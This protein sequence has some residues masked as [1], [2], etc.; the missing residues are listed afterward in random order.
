MTLAQL[1]E[2]AS[3]V[4]ARMLALASKGHL[5][6]GADADLIVV[7]PE[8]RQP[9]LT[10]AAGQVICM[11][12]TVIGRGS[13]VLTTAAGAAGLKE[14]GIAHRVVDLSRSLLYTKGR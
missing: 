10:V 11:D 12:G 2:K 13:T 14:R 4:P 9:A 1:A 7:D 8:R 3:V 5:A 6:P